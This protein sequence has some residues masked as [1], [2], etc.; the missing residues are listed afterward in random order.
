MNFATSFYVSPSSSALVRVWVNVINGMMEK[1]QNSNICNGKVFFWWLVA[2]QFNGFVPPRRYLRVH[3]NFFWTFNICC[4]HIFSWADFFVWMW[5]EEHYHKL[6]RTSSTCHGFIFS[7]FLLL[8]RLVVKLNSRGSRRGLKGATNG[9]CARS[10]ETVVKVNSEAAGQRAAAAWKWAR[11]MMMMIT[12]RNPLSFT[13][14]W[15][16]NGRKLWQLRNGKT[17]A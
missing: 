13:P 5:G 12:D 1:Y 11:Q 4:S 6:N 10:S 14:L 17:Y 9:Q 15:M 7:T 2:F 16:C 3:R 8:L